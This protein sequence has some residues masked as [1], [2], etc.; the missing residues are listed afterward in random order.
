M[1]SNPQPSQ[2]SNGEVHLNSRS[3]RQAEQDNCNH[4]ETQ[5]QLHG[6]DKE[7]N[8]FFFVLPLSSKEPV[9]QRRHGGGRARRCPPTPKMS[10]AA[11]ITQFQSCSSSPFTSG[12]K[13]PPSYET[14]AVV[15]IAERPLPPTH[16]HPSTPPPPH[17]KL[18]QLVSA[19]C[20]NSQPW[21][22]GNLG[23]TAG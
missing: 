5:Q 14:T 18:T 10:R 21:K 22:S 1:T 8:I 15:E 12:K 11:C 7:I 17:L 2:Q 6:M 4:I 19:K 20:S 9:C 13:N 23:T 16:L 3:Q